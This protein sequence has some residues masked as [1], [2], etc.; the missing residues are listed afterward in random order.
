MSSSTAVAT[1][2]YSFDATA[3]EA[4]AGGSTTAHASETVYVDTTPPALTITSPAANATVSGRVAIGATATDAMGVKSVEF[5]V[6]NVLIARDTGTPYTASWNTHKSSSGPH[7]IMVKATD[8][9]GNVTSQ[10][11]TVTVK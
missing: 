5:Y 2:T 7:A 1:G 8:N 4:S 10:S 6:D 3:A 11:I 9:G